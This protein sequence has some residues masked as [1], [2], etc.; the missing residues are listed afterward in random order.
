PG[1][2]LLAVISGAGW[3][4]SRR[5]ASREPAGGTCSRCGGKVQ[6]VYFRCPHCG[7]T[8]K[9]N[10]PGCSRVVDQNWDFCPYC[11]TALKAAAEQ[12]VTTVETDQ[13]TNPSNRRR[14]G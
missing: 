10:C 3:L 9:H 8:L 12:P 11:R 14:T 2:F 5:N 4:W 13:S 1:L 7:D 6:E